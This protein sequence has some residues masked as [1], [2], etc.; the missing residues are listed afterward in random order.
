M[1]ASKIPSDVSFSRTP[2]LIRKG[3]TLLERAQGNEDRREQTIVGAFHDLYYNGPEHQSEIFKRTY[4]MKVP[5]QKCPLDL[6]VYQEIIAEIRPD[7]IIETGT[8]FGGSA[9][10]LAN[11]LDLVGKGEVVTIDIEERPARPVHPRIKYVTGSSANSQLIQSILNDRPEEIRLVVLD[12]DHSKSHVL[13]ELNLF[14]PYV[15]LGSYLIVEDTNVNGHPTYPSFGE[16]PY[17]AV[18]EFLH[19]TDCFIRDYSKEKF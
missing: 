19:Q 9:L 18:D 17:E 16:G 10:F 7:L 12:S 3:K 13:K 11:M 6:W 8:L 4:W 15:S 14:A 5:C 1:A 2:S